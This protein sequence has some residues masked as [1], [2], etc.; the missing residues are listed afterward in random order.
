[1]HARVRLPDHDSSYAMLCLSRVGEW[2][3]GFFAGSVSKDMVD[4]FR[5]YDDIDSPSA[6][7][8]N[9]AFSPT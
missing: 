4:C 1:M 9:V 7:R 5:L 2:D 8:V 3:L 6:R